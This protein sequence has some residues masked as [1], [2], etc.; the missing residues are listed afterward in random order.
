[1]TQTSKL[2]R[3]FESLVM[4]ET[5]GIR[6]I[7][8]WRS[9]SIPIFLLLDI[10]HLVILAIFECLESLFDSWFVSPILNKDKSLEWLKIGI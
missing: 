1:M 3:D 5:W 7:S 10:R 8:D 6:V 2:K 9:T 4:I